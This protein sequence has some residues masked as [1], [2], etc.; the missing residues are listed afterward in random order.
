MVMDKKKVISI[1]LLVIG[2]AALVV[3][4]VF[5]IIKL[6][7]G[8]TMADGEYLVEVG[9]WKLES[10]T[11]CANGEN[12]NETLEVN[13]EQNGVTEQEPVESVTDINCKNGVVWQ[14]TE[15]GKGTLTTNSHLND[16][17]FEWT[18]EDGKLKMR[19]K[20]LYQL[21]NEY[22]YSLDQ[23]TGRLVLHD[24]DSETVFVKE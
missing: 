24:G 22:E 2:I 7:S 1:S 23:G 12:S 14:F 21:E 15:I 8:P 6:N 13:S 20:W 3:G 10:D 4:A 19:T 17:D 18:I 9:K 5:L 16:Y 11:G